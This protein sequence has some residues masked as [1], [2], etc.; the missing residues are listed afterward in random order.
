MDDRRAR[1]RTAAD[2]LVVLDGSSFFVSG[3]AGDVMPGPD[4]TGYFFADVRHL[5][6]WRLLV[7]GEPVR[8]LSSRAV[9]Y[10][11]A[12]IHATLAR[13]RVGRNPAVSIRRDRFLSDGVHEDLVV[14]NHSQQPAAVRVELLFAADFMDIFEVKEPRA[15]AGITS[16]EVGPDRVT[17]RY[18]RGGFSRATVLVFGAPARLEAGRALFELRLEPRH[19][20]RCC[21]DVLCVAD[22]VTHWPGAT[23]QLVDR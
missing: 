4:A 22:G 9:E 3:S 12:S 14:E 8:L 11:A 1:E 6:T 10:Y 7:D 16:T 15:K 5:S 21:I 13:V 18:D 19:R 20:W 23:C 17:L 2:T